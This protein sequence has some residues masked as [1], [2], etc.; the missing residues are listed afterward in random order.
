MKTLAFDTSTAACAAALAI[1]GESFET[2]PPATRLLEKPA[3]TTE[4]LPTILDLTIQAGISLGE[5]D[6]VVVGV[7]PGAFT[8][9]RIGIATARAIATANG[10]GIVPISSLAVLEEG[11]LKEDVMT[12][13]VIDARRK[14]F[15]FRIG[16]LDQLAGPEETVEALSEAAFFKEAIGDGAIKL[17]DRLSAAGVAVPDDDDPMH[18]LSAAT[19]IDLARDLTPIAPDQVVPNYI[20]PPD[21][22]VSSRES[23]LVAGT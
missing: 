11:Q 5:V 18:V 6:R 20:R 23:W 4:L 15:F 1:D 12:A 2:R 9:L 13:A 17:R 10:I 19:M 21:A 3:H 14:E 16:G 7:G 22:K 8:G